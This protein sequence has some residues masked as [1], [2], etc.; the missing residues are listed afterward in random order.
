MEITKKGI[1]EDLFEGKCGACFCEAQT[2]RRELA[3]IR[4]Y[5]SLFPLYTG[6]KITSKIT[7]NC[8]VCGQYRMLMECVEEDNE[9]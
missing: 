3:E 2:T 1:S 9:I 5:D 8:P 7:I 4:P 6:A